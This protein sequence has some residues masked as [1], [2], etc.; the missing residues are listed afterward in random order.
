MLFA[1]EILR[2]SDLRLPSFTSSALSIVGALILGDAAVNAGI[3]SPV[4]IIVIA[5]TSVS[6]LLFTEPEIINGI[7]IVRLGFM[8]AANIMGVIGIAFLFLIFVIKLCSLDSFGFPYLSP[9]SPIS[10]V[11]LK[12]SIIKFPTKYLNKREKSLSSNRIRLRINS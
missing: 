1:F 6:S 12:N 5:I 3:V 8:M 9:L 2:E 7:R 10:F 11:G 4:M